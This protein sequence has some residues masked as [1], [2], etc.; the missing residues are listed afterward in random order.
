MPGWGPLSP[1]RAHAR[2]AAPPGPA[3]TRAASAAAGTGPARCVGSPHP[4]A[5]VR[6]TGPLT[7]APCPPPT[8]PRRRAGAREGRPGRRGRRSARL[9]CGSAPAPSRLGPGPPA[10]PAERWA[11]PPP[12]TCPA[13]P[14]RSRQPG[15]PTGGAAPGFGGGSLTSAGAPPRPAPGPASAPRK[16]RSGRPG[17][18]GARGPRAR[19]RPASASRA[20][21]LSPSPLGLPDPSPPA[22]RPASP[23]G[24][25]PA[26]RAQPG[27]RS[28]PTS[29]LRARARLTL[30]PAPGARSSSRTPGLSPSAPPDPVR[31]GGR[32]RRWGA[33]GRAPSSRASRAQP[34][35]FSR[36]AGGRRVAG[37]SSVPPGAGHGVRERV[38]PGRSPRAGR[39][40]RG[41]RCPRSSRRR[42]I[43]GGG[44]RRSEVRPVGVLAFTV[45]AGL[46]RGSRRAARAR[47]ALGAGLQGLGGRSRGGFVGATGAPCS[48]HPEL[49]G[50]PRP[51]P[52]S[53]APD[54]ARP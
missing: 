16:S 12:R 27:A 31:A 28:R 2:S 34:Q 39:Y 47:E 46:G 41:V 9:T 24:P 14:A 53:L 6:P 37:A 11:G 43:N 36:R 38:P 33:P 22:L 52:R 3:Q 32:R 25:A 19:A 23:Q 20:G 45:W 18:P 13:R 42:G 54:R 50:P 40:H 49:R 10:R 29:W 48:A 35:A 30:N 26:Y 51:V 5:F 4:R 7:S 8:R 44:R 21:R 15:E 1:G 17:A